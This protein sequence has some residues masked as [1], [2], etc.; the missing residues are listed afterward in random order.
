MRQEVPGLAHEI[1]RRL[2]IRHPDMD[3]QAEDQER[4]RQLL[5][6]FDDALVANA[7]REHLVLPVRKR[8][9]AGGRDS[10]AG[11][12]RRLGELMPDPEQLLPELTDVLADR[13]ADLDD[14]LMQLSFDLIAEDRS[15]RQQQLRHVRPEFSAV[16]V[17]DLKFLFDAERKAEHRLLIIYWGSDCRTSPRISKTRRTFRADMPKAS[18]F[19]AL[20]A[21]LPR[22]CRTPSRCC[23]SA[24]S[25]H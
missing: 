4:S 24:P 17:D 13:R 9:G 19:R 8:M 22:R 21:R 2:P 25:R 14:R 12:I 10:E 23:R 7:G 18:S 15:A 11:A 20:P 3:V 6:F 16:G 5:Q 1:D